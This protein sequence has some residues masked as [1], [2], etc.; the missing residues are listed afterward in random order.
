MPAFLL[1]AIFLIVFVVWIPIFPARSSVTDGMAWLD[2]MR[3]R[4]LPACTRAIA[5]AAYA[6]RMLRDNLIEVLESD[7]V[8][9]AELKG[10]SRLQVLVMHALPNALEIG[11]AS[12]RER[13]CQY[14]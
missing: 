9:M 12:C 3:A 1:A 2:L 8:R 10:L 14:V 6:V 4:A 7:Y 5:M 13:V 11:R